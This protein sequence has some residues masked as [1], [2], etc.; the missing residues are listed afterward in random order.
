MYESQTGENIFIL[1]SNF[2]DA[3]FPS[4]KE[5]IISVSTDAASN[6][7]VRHWGVVLLLDE[8]CLSDFS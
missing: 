2:M 5:E 1:I 8:V 4:W 6:V 3:I 7:H